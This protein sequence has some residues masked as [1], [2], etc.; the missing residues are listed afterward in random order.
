L[1]AETMESVDMKTAVAT[2]FRLDHLSFVF[3]FFALGA[4]QR[5]PVARVEREHKP[6]DK[7]EPDTCEC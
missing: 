7:C 1:L 6:V 5:G 2:R 3:S 4:C